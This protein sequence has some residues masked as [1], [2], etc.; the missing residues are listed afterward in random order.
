MLTKSKMPKTHRRRSFFISKIFRALRERLATIRVTPKARMLLNGT[1]GPVG[2]A[3]QVY[4]G[5][6]QQISMT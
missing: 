5:T 6:T 3:S 1:A 2:E 4:T